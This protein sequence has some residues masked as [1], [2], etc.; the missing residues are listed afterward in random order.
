MVSRS[1]SRRSRCPSRGRWYRSRRPCQVEIAVDLKDADLD[2]AELGPEIDVDLKDADPGDVTLGPASLN[3]DLRDADLRDAD[4][5]LQI[6]TLDGNVS[7]EPERSKVVEAVEHLL[8]G[9]WSMR[10]N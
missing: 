5:A 4:P 7:D 1:E 8:A 9:H 10:S 6:A 3:A 2:D